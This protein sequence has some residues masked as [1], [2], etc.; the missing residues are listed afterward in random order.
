GPANPLSPGSYTAYVRGRNA[1]GVGEWSAA[2]GFTAS[3]PAAVPS[4]PSGPTYT[5]TP[6]YTWSASA[7]ATSYF[8][9]VGNGTAIVFQGGYAASHVS[10][11]EGSSLARPS[12]QPRA[13][14]L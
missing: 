11:G 8:L 5:P 12:A 13:A 10:V 6:T 14:Y 7:G 4:S 9:Q 2:R 1:V 3:P